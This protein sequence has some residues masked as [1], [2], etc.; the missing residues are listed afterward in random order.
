MN[1]AVTLTFSL[2]Y[3]VNFSKSS[4]LSKKVQLMMSNDVPLLVSY[5]FGQG[6]IRYY[7]AP[8]IGDE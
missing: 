6:H 7:L 3:L 2:K 1:Q 5:A 8:K 4:S